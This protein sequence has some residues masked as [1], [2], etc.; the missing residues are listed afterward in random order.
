MAAE[1]FGNLVEGLFELF[2]GRDFDGAAAG[3]VRKL[4]RDIGAPAV[5][6][7]VDQQ[8]VHD[9]VGFLRGLDGFF[10]TD[11][12]AFVLGVG[13]DDEGFSARFRAELFRAS[14]I[15]RVVEVRATGVRRNSS[16]CDDP[17]AADGVDAR[18]VDGAFDDVLVVGEIA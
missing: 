18:L 16:G 17:T 14:E 8:H 11:F 3:F 6:W 13:D 15:D 1:L 2:L 4:F 10:E 9:R 7:V 12:A 5:A